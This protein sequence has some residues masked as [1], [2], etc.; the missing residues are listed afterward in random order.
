ML[1]VRGLRHRKG[2]RFPLWLVDRNDWT[3]RNFARWLWE[4]YPRAMIATPSRWHRGMF[5]GPGVRF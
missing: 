4:D 2:N 1:L 3:R 5:T